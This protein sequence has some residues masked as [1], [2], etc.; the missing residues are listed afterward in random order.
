MNENDART[1][2]CPHMRRTINMPDGT[3]S[4]GNHEGYGYY[5]GEGNCIGSDC[6]MWQPWN[7][8][9]STGDCGLKRKS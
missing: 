3:C 6:M 9:E 7:E 8:A 5:T 4:I 1:K 2:W